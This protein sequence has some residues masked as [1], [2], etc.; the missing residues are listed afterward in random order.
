MAVF[1]DTVFE[2]IEDFIFSRRY[3]APT[4]EQETPPEVISPAA[5]AP[6]TTM[7]PPLGAPPLMP[8]I[9]LVDIEAILDHEAANKK[10]DW[11]GSIHD[12][13]T[14]CGIEP[15]LENRQSLAGEL[16]VSA[17]DDEALYHAVMHELE[18]RGG[19]VP[20]ELRE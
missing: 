8:L 3:D 13:M 5:I 10:L 6:A 17:G 19:Q 7:S 16:G 15:T 18:D 14:L 4:L 1:Y 12:L 11:R 9:G 2:A 20:V